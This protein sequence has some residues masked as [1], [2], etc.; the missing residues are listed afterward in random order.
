MSKFTLGNVIALILVF[1]FTL[2]CK[3]DEK[4]CSKTGAPQIHI[5]F[6]VV[7]HNQE[8]NATL[9]NVQIEKRECGNTATGHMNLSGPAN[10]FGDFEGTLNV[11]Y[12][13]N[14]S[15]DKVVVQYDYDL[16]SYHGGSI[17]S[18]E[19][20]IS[21]DDLA[22]A[23]GETVVVDLEYEPNNASVLWE[24][25][26]DYKTRMAYCYDLVY[27]YLY[28]SPPAYGADTSATKTS[29]YQK[30]IQ[31]GYTVRSQGTLN[32]SLYIR[33]GDILMFGT[34]A[35]PDPTN[36]KHYALVFD[37]K[38]YNIIHWTQ[39]SQF[40][41]PRM[42]EDFLYRPVLLNPYNG[43]DYVPQVPF[44]YYIAFNK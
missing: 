34:T 35:P 2:S 13:L 10:Q 39:G 36:A 12:D 28:G 9:V 4:D 40:D 42:P 7:S 16:S 18:G 37:G 15:E 17:R 44:Q 21:Y 19:E 31:S 14:N 24:T 41:G 22:S 3:L 29:V 32:S 43:I 20:Y 38:I 23:D 33:D 5:H 25:W 26:R 11:S 30:M 6:R 8:R 27:C 1:F